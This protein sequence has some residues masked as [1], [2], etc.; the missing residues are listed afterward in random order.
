MT[1]LR[2]T[3]IAQGF[4]ILEFKIKKQAIAKKLSKSKDQKD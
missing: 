1:F 4:K 3:E 2:Y